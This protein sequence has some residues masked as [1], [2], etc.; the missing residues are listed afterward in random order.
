MSGLSEIGLAYAMLDP[1][2]GPEKRKRCEQWKAARSEQD[3]AFSAWLIENAER[4]GKLTRASRSAAKKEAWAA[5][6]PSRP[7][8]VSS[9]P[10]EGREAAKE[11]KRA[12][13][14]ARRAEAEAEIMQ[15]I[16]AGRLGRSGLA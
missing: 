1:M 6:S 8:L 11:A 16:R 2:K 4:L 13:W 12:A 9:V 14:L 3:R 15:Q 7:P 10:P 5:L